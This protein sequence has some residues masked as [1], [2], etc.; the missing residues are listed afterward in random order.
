ML[1]S[2]SLAIL[3]FLVNMGVS[4]KRG[5]RLLLVPRLVLV[6]LALRNDRLATCIKANHVD[7]VVLGWSVEDVHLAG[8][9]LVSLRDEYLVFGSSWEPPV[10]LLNYLGGDLVIVAYFSQH[11]PTTCIYDFH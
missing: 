3:Y 5:C 9:S 4:N 6:A 8:H 10:L 1:I 11:D 2:F 7:E